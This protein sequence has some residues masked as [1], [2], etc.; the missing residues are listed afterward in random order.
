MAVEMERV[1]AFEVLRRRRKHPDLVERLG[2]V[3]RV[4]NKG[5]YAWVA[6]AIIAERDSFIG[7]FAT[8]RLAR[9]AIVKHEKA[10]MKSGREKEGE[11]E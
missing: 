8:P 7:S 11:A 2:H 9:E 4:E 10:L 5:D 1:L 6:Y 3:V